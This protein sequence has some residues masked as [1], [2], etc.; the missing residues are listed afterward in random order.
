[1]EV[2]REREEKAEKV[3]C[4]DRMGYNFSSIFHFE[5]EREVKENGYLCLG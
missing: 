2:G 3:T 1:M 5:S 4:N